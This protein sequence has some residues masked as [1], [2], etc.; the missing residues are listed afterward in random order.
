M[1][2]HYHVHI[3]TVGAEFDGPITKVLTAIGGIDKLYL[4]YTEYENIEK[5]GN[6]EDRVRTEDR[7]GST[8]NMK[9]FGSMNSPD[10]GSKPSVENITYKK[11]KS[12]MLAEKIEKDYEHSIRSIVTRRIPMFDFQ[13]IVQNVFGIYQEERGPKVDFSVN[14][15][16]GTN[17]MAAALCYVSYYIGAKIWYAGNMKGPISE[18]VKEVASPKAIDVDKMKPITKDFLKII[19]DKTMKDEQ[20]SLGEACAIRGKEITKQTATYQ[21]KLLINLGLIKECDYIVMKTIDGVQVETV[22]KSKKCLKVTMNGA[23]IGA[24]LK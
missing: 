7:D 18:Q 19:Y 23:M 16:G 15:T 22:N 10:D 6:I 3:A 1:G 14:I 13:G 4:L 17:L 11:S 9:G 12:R 5:D 24:Y 21:K 2:K 8:N 20:V